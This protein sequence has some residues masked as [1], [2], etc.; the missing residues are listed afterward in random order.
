MARKSLPPKVR[1]AQTFLVGDQIKLL[2]YDFRWMAI[3]DIRE[4]EDGR[5]QLILEDGDDFWVTATQ[6]VE[7]RRVEG[8]A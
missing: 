4:F 6:T 3:T 2:R 1:A 5:R 8:G 7:H